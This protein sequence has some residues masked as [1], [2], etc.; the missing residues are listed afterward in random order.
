[1]KNFIKKIIKGLKIKFDKQAIE[2]RTARNFLKNQSGG[3]AV[4]VAFTLIPLIILTGIAIDISRVAYVETKLQY[5][6]DAAAI[7]GIEY[8]SADLQFNAQN[9]FYA[10]FPPGSY[11]SSIQMTATR[12]EDQDFNI[13]VNVKVNGTIPSYFGAFVGLDT[14]AVN[15]I[16]QT[17]K[18][19]EGLEFAMVLD[20]TGSMT[21]S[22]KMTNLKIAATNMINILYDDKNSKPNFAISII[23]YVATVNVG[24]THQDWLSNPGQLSKFTSNV[25]WQG[26]MGIRESDKDLTDAPP[27]NGGWPVYLAESTLPGAPTCSTPTT[28]QDN[29][30]CYDSQGKLVVKTS[31]TNEVTAIG[32]NRSCGLPILPHQNDAT[33]LRKLINQMQ[34]VN[35]GGTFGDL[36]L[37]WGWRTLSPRWLNLWKSQTGYPKAYNS[38]NNRKAL[39]IMTDGVNNW[40]DGPYLPTGG[41]PTAYGFG[42]TQA[43]RIGLN[44]LGTTVNSQAKGKI[45]AKYT[46]LCN[47]IKAQ[48]I[49][50][51]VVTFLLNDANSQALYRN[52]ATKPEWYFNAQESTDIVGIFETIA[53][54]IQPISVTE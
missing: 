11:D 14:L 45:D 42:S 41:D 39:L 35:G 26:C 29:D 2:N 10:N 17:K 38:P 28:A 6:A 51:Y 12:E 37:V 27:S 1:M 36:G 48:G 4:I 24:N 46:T 23:P 25:P 49:E 5:A 21:S 31:P 15:V 44:N 43:T 13:F 9:L 20:N 54:L 40:N 3:I 8:D 18:A 22:N 30:W 52:C 7:A 16:S 19:A 50:V 33:A 53:R 47:S 34:P 32:P